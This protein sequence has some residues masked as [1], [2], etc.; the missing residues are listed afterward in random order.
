PRGE[1]RPNRRKAGGGGVLT[2]RRGGRPPER[3]VSARLPGGAAGAIDSATRLAHKMVCVWGMSEK[4]GPLTFGKREEMVFLGREIAT[5][6]DYSEQTAMLIDEEVRGLVEGAYSKAL[7]LL[8][9]NM[10]K[11]HLLAAALLEREVLDG[12]ERDRLLKGEKLEPPRTN[13]P[14][15]G[16]TAPEAAKSELAEKPT[17]M[18]PLQP[19]PRPAT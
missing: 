19:Q 7:D 10:D 12:D 6:K 9:A 14:S 13:E 3:L 2:R 4:L 11:L 16:A 8:R 1:A 15:S 5:Q 18:P 17:A